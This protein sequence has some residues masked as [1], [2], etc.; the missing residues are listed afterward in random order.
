MRGIATGAVDAE[1]AA[2]GNAVVVLTCL[3][4]GALAA[5]DPGEHQALLADPDALRLR[6]ERFDDTERLV[7]EGEGQHAAA[8]LHV[9]ALAAAQ[10]EVALPDVQIRVAYAFAGDAHQHF[11]AFRLRRGRQHFLERLAVLDDLVADH[12]FAASLSAWSMSHR[13]SSSVSMPTEMRIM[14][15][16]TPALTRSASSICLWVVDAG[17][18]TSVLASPMLARWLMNCAASMK[19]SPALAPPLTPKLSKPEAPLGRYFFASA[20]YLLSGR[21]G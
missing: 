7:A 11:A 5:A 13:M 9:E 2:P 14:S 8:L 1:D 17:W 3:A 21:P 10:I 20:W 16:V 4:H 18:M 19:R 12:A 6:S 15:G